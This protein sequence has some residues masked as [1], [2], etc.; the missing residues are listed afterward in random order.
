MIPKTIRQPADII[1]A[2]TPLLLFSTTSSTGSEV[3]SGVC[4]GSGGRRGL[5]G[6][7]F[8]GVVEGAQ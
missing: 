3:A 6:Q 1:H 8:S 5:I 7:D 4:V 2:I